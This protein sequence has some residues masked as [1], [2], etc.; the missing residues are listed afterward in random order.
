MKIY[1]P[2]NLMFL[3]IL[4]LSIVTKAQNEVTP[5]YNYAISPDDILI[6]VFYGSP[7][8][9]FFP[10]APSAKNIISDFG[11]VGLRL[12][13]VTPK[14]TAF[15]NSNFGFGIE[16]SYS[17][18]KASEELRFLRP[19]NPIGPE[20]YDNSDSLITYSYSVFRLIPRMDFHIIQSERMD[21]NIG[22]GIG[23]FNVKSDEI[24]LPDG[25][26]FLAIEKPSNPISMRFFLGGKYFV[27]DNIGLSVSTGL[28]GGYIVKVGFVVKV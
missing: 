16:T 25:S 19:T 2:R 4:F 15:H 14:L 10:E 5:D 6:E 13:F 12:E 3:S 20:T 28:G 22:I 21:F 1:S 11:V 26:R 23:T 7:A 27:S 18:G 9:N 17:S 8:V 24:S